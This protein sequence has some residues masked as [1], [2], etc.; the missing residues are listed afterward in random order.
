MHEVGSIDILI[1][2]A[3]REQSFNPPHLV[4]LSEMEDMFDTNLFAPF[5]MTK[6]FLAMPPPKSGGQK[7]LLNISS[8]AAHVDLLAGY[9]ASKAAFAQMVHHFAN[10]EATKPV[11]ERT[12]MFCYHPGIVYTESVS[13]SSGTGRLRLL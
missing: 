13:R 1:F 4:D 6:T 9:G 2:S 7:T 11:A 10:H 3:V 8:C 12:R 5:E